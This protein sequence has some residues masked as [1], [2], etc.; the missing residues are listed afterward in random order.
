MEDYEINDVRN[1]RVAYPSLLLVDTEIEQGVFLNLFVEN[2]SDLPAQ[3]IHFH[4]HPALHWETGE[5]LPFSRGISA[6]QPHKRLSFL[7]GSVHQAFD[8][9]SNIVK[10]F[11]VSTTYFHSGAAHR[12]TETYAIDIQSYHGTSSIR[13][14]VYH[15]GKKLESA[16]LKI[17]AELKQLN[18]TLE[19]VANIAGPTGIDLSVTALRNLAA[20]R[21][22]TP[23][24]ERL[25][26]ER[27]STAALQEVLGI[28]RELAIGNTRLFKGTSNNQLFARSL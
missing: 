28:D 20:I 13:P 1:R 6:L 4:F 16:L 14:E 8:E 5:P 9:N 17:V 26:T 27:I 25:S 15:Q 10:A 21:G 24:L 18:Q 11:S 23:N 7:Y 3:D 19:K 2:I 22:V 12:V